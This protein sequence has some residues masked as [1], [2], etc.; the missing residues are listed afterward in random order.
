M[1]GKEIEHVGEEDEEISTLSDIII[2][3]VA[4]RKGKRREGGE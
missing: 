4:S 2:L 3:V 1:I